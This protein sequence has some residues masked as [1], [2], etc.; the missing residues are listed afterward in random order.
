MT[1]EAWLL[2]CLT[3]TA[4]CLSPGPS[5]LLVISLGLTRGQAAGTAA[6][7]GVL[8]A[9]AIYFLLSASGLVAAYALSAEV[10]STIKWAG[11][12]YLI[13]LGLRMVYRSFRH[14]TKT[15]PTSAAASKGRSFWQGLVTQGANP[16]LLVY[17][18][19]ILPQF[20]DTAYPLPRQVAIL[21]SSSFV[22]EFTVLAFYAALAHRASRLAAGR[23][24]AVAE[25]VGGGLLV[26]AGAGLASLRRT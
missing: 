19:A 24:S 13:W 1:V 7:A 4:L 16:N 12:L 3:E 6:T 20:I 18:T 26:A 14:H 15:L 11:A 21:A 5:A 25:R 22:I 10:F 17:F 9:N 23:S 2:F 8:V